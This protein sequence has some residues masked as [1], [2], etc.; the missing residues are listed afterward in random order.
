MEHVG[1]R[2]LLV[3]FIAPRG[4]TPRLVDGNGRFF[5]SMSLAVRAGVNLSDQSARLV[6]G[7]P[8]PTGMRGRARVRFQWLE[9]DLRLARHGPR[10][11]R[12]LLSTVREAARSAHSTTSLRD[13]VPVPVRTAVLLRSAGRRGQADARQAG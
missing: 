9:D 13:S 7:L 11:A 1:L 3:D 6:V 8:T 10:R 12:A 5:G 4:E 2:P